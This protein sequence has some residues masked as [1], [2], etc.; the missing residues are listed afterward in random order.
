FILIETGLFFISLY[1]LKM[2][3]DSVATHAQNPMESPDVLNNIVL[4]GI[5]GILYLAF[6]SLS[7]YVGEVQSA[8]IAEH[9]SDKIHD[10]TIALDLAFYESSDYF[11]VLNRALNAGTERPTLIINT[12]FEI[13]KSFMS[14]IAFGTVLI[15]ID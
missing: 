7:S 9:M 11:D 12:L 4:A 6:K 3:I 10:K 5:S 2:L 13:M 14:L 1:A 8:T 15:T